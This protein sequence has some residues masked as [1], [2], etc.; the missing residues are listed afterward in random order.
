M[1]KVKFRFKSPD[2]F[3]NWKML[4]GDSKSVYKFP[5]DLEF[6]RSGVVGIGTKRHNCDGSVEIWEIF[7][8]DGEIVETDRIAILA[9]ECDMFVDVGEDVNDSDEHSVHDEITELCHEI[10]DM[11]QKI[12]YNKSRLIELLEECDEEQRRWV[13]DVLL[14]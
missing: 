9:N 10:I 12:S 13:L 8:Q 14:K 11:K 1:E 7:G 3:D 6:L 5:E 2:K 4:W